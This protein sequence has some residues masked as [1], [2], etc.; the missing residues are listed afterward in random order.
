MEEY[1]GEIR[2][3]GYNWAPRNWDN[4]EGQLLDIGS[5]QALYSL[6]GT[7]FGG[8]GRTSFAL[9]DLRGRV[10]M[11]ADYYLNQVGTMYGMETVTLTTHELAA[12]QHDFNATHANASHHAL[13]PSSTRHF[14]IS[15][16]TNTF[17][18]SNNLVQMNPAAVLP[19]GSS[20]AHENR[21]PS[22]AVNFIICLD[23]LYPSRN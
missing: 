8:N 7:Q 13:G 20:Q 10:P 3:V 5:Y 23:G 15:Q 19:A 16:G 9:P 18:P 17:G 1:L 22:T 2:I 12:H 14:G 21:Q 6:L 4:C 11:H